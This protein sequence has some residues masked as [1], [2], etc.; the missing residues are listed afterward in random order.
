MSDALSKECT[1][2]RSYDLFVE[3][4]GEAINK[5]RLDKRLRQE[6]QLSGGKR[7]CIDDPQQLNVDARQE[8][9]G[10]L[11]IPTQVHQ[12]IVSTI[13]AS[14]MGGVEV[15]QTFG[16]RDPPLSRTKGFNLGDRPKSMYEK[17]SNK[18]KKQKAV[19]KCSKCRLPGHKKPQCPQNNPVML[20]Y[21]GLA[22]LIL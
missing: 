7:R 17:A 13:G 3:G 10:D 22:V 18:L 15:H 19:R 1:D 20:K 16:L 4:I 2:D 9:D 12:N 21:S 6:Q 8:G 14:S 11:H 5:V